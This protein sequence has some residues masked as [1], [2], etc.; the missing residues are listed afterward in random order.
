MKTKIEICMYAS[1]GDKALS[2]W[3]V[4]VDPLKGPVCLLAHDGNSVNSSQPYKMTIITFENITAAT[5]LCFKKWTF[6]EVVVYKWFFSAVSL[7]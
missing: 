7:M 5:S 3:V 6:F 1:K 2:E 4:I